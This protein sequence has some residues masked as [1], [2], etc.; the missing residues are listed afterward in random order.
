VPRTSHRSALAAAVLLLLTVLSAAAPLAASA[1]DGLTM[2]AR[3][4]LDGHARPGSWIAIDIRIVNEGPAVSGEVR[5]AGGLQGRTQF[6]TPVEAPTQSDQTHRL[7]AQPPGFGQTITIELVDGESVVASTKASFALHDPTQVVIGI[8]AESPGDIVG[9]LDLLPNQNNIAPLVI[10]LAPS[11]LPERVEAWRTLDS[12]LWQDS[13]S[14]ALSTRQH[15][16]ARTWVAGGGRLVILGG[17]SG[18]S[19]LSAFTEDILPYRP[20][21][22]TDVDP[23]SLT[24]LLGATPDDATD[25]PALT[26]E[27]TSGRALATSGDR[28]VAAERSV[29]AGGVTIIGF[30]PTVDWISDRGLVDGLW[31][32]VIP[33]RTGASPTIGDDSQM[34]T[35]AAQLPS[36]SLPPLGWL[37]ALLGAY[38]LLIGPV[39]YLV[40][41][42]LDKREWAWVTMPALIVVFSVS[43]YGIGA[44]LR[45]TD[46]IINEAAIVRGA[47]GRSE[48]TASVYVGLFSPT[49]STYQVRFPGGALLSSPLNSDV[50]GTDGTQSTL[51]VLQGD[52]ARIRDLR[53]GFGSLRTVRAETSTS[54]PLVEADIR[55]ADGRLLG[56]VTN[57]SSETISSPAVVLGGTVAKLA[58]LAP[59]ETATFDVPV[60]RFVTDRPLADQIVGQ[61]FFEDPSNISDDQARTYARQS[62]INQLTYDPAFGLSG[63]LPADG[64]VILGWGVQSLLPIEIDGHVAR[65]TAN[66]LWFIPTELRASGWV[67]FGSDLLRSS[68]VRSDA[69]MF[70]KDPYNISF[71]EGEVELSYRPVAFGGSIEA[72]ELVIGLNTFGGVNLG[73]PGAIEPLPQIPPPC[74]VADDLECIQFDGLPELELYDLEAATWVRLPHLGD[75]TR[76][77]IGNPE[78]Y[79]DPATGT[80][81][82][83]LL[84][85]RPDSVYFNLELE[86]TGTIG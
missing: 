2:E 45:G 75:G 72:T 50:F 73:K 40:L 11:E 49:R 32:Q 79:V 39:N 36:L 35:A 5:L 48:G 84:T 69:G 46:L 10:V 37:I 23:A 67:R 13:D 76:N 25:L 27:L 4:L 80:V 6:G 21:A 3:V 15:E 83:K 81:L 68:V 54:V 33:S 44:F 53:V 47:P 9:S 52:P 31:R 28:V 74:D 77:A 61:V 60:D 59:G 34:V 24:V 7:Y 63:P 58:D 66:V 56:S 14:S 55:V 41:R 29:G 57:A 82:L 1:A 12:L 86:I 22:T 8:V 64:P 26:G 42:R 17:T 16:A 51:D 20:T 43:A 18:P 78:R 38:I 30:D 85:D 65:R 19:S 62:I 70:S 71:A